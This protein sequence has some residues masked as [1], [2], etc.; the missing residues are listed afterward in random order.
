MRANQP[1]FQIVTKLYTLFSMHGNNDIAI[2]A[3]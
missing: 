2:V 1:L 3:R